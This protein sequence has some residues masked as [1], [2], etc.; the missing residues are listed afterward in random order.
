MPHCSTQLVLLALP[1]TNGK[2]TRRKTIPIPVHTLPSASYESSIIPYSVTFS[3]I[4]TVQVAGIEIISKVRF[5]ANVSVCGKTLSLWYF[6]N[7]CMKVQARNV[8]R[9][10]VVVKNGL[11]K[12]L[13][14]KNGKKYPKNVTCMH[15]KEMYCWFIYSCFH[16]YFYSL[17]TFTSQVIGSKISKA[18]RPLFTDWVI[19]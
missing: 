5:S 9:L 2:Y 1:S 13:L 8:I 12:K 3:C 11:C 4:A 16:N 6:F 15:N 17:C 7:T 10:F 19:M 18:I 14:S